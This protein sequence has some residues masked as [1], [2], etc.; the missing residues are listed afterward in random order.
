MALIF[1]LTFV[2]AVA[3]VAG[4]A[5][6]AVEREGGAAAITAVRNAENVK[7]VAATDQFGNL[8]NMN[9]GEIAIRLPGI[10]GELDAGGNLSGFTVRCMTSAALTLPCARL[11]R[12]SASS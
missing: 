10:Y 11:S 12:R 3:L 1:D 9:A 7:N 4:I 6:V 5:L 8:P 2:I